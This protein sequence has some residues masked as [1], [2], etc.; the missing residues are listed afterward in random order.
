[1]SRLCLVTG[2]GFLLAGGAAYAQGFDG[3]RFTPA[4]GAAGG[5]QVERPVVP[6]HL[7]YGLGLFL[8][9]EKNPVVVRDRQTGGEVGKL[10]DHGLSADLLAS[11]GLF[12]WF[13]LAMSLPV[14]LVY[15]GTAATVD[16]A[17]LSADAGAGDLRLVP[18]VSFG[19]SGD[20]SSGHVLGLAAPVTLPTGRP[21]A[22]R[23]A[24]G[25]T[26]EPRLLAMFYGERWLFD[27]SAGFRFRD[28]DIPSAPGHE[29]TF[30]LAGTYT[31]RIENDPIDLQLEAVGGWLPQA[32]GRAL[33]S[34]PL[35]LLGAVVWKPAPRWA[36]YAGGGLGATNGVGVPDG[37]ALIGVRYRVGVPGRGG[38]RDSD[39]DGIPDGRDR[40]PTEPE[41]MDGF[42]DDDGCPDPDNDHD[43]VA[44][45]VDE[46]PDDAEEP[47]GDRDGCPDRP[48]VIVRKGK[49]V[50]YG[51]VL[52]PVESAQMLPKSE[53]L[54]EEMARALKDHRLIK[55]VEI[56]GHTDS[57]GDPSF[58]K[59]LSQERADAVKNALIRRGVDGGRL[60]PRGYGEERPIAPNLTHAGRAKNRRVEFTIL[61]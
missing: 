3:E 30:G 20:P 59:K 52:F 38:V 5:L 32:D 44:D 16:G 7:G 49:L 12:D 1:M 58:N 45:D 10:V 54:I 29:L 55:R 57:T 13:E 4:T 48:R 42:H 19:W 8:N 28:R 46:C 53:P 43:G 37:R 27:A 15:S 6:T 9:F 47:G 31:P 18:K 35:E 56:E 14:R 50:I 11:L 51:K 33:S 24:G 60:V 21:D 61:D 2:L 17:A 41:D 26:V 25:V 34:L 23:G 22:V 40:C 39:S 36:V